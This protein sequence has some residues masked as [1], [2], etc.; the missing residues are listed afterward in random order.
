MRDVLINFAQKKSSVEL[1]I[2]KLSDAA[3]KSELKANFEKF[4]SELWELRTKPCTCESYAPGQVEKC[5]STPSPGQSPP[6]RVLNLTSGSFG[7]DHLLFLLFTKSF[8]PGHCP[9]IV[10][11]LLERWIIWL[12]RV[13][14]M[15]WRFL[16]GIERLAN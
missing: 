13:C 4:D 7:K 14:P 11:A 9:P 5:R 1:C 10:G 16:K 12:T 3:A 6:N 2:N 15:A 8:T